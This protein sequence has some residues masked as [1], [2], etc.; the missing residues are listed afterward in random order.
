MVWQRLP[1]GQVGSPPIKP[2]SDSAERVLQLLPSAADRQILHV[3]QFQGG[4]CLPT[5]VAKADQILVYFPVLP[6]TFRARV[7]AVRSRKFFEYVDRGKGYCGY[8]RFGAF[9]WRPHH[10][11][12]LCPISKEAWYVVA[13]T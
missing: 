7:S 12:C 6:W 5:V 11:R 9:K 4:S 1:F 2:L 13:S 10:H 3:L 8:G